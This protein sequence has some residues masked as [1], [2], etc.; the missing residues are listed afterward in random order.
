MAE[1]NQ[2]RILLDLFWTNKLKDWECNLKGNTTEEEDVSIYLIN[3]SQKKNWEGCV[4][5]TYFINKV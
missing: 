5:Q 3:K 1:K 2:I 4:P